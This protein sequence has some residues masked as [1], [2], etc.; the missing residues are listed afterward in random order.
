MNSVISLVECFEKNP[1]LSIFENFNEVKINCKINSLTIPEIAFLGEVTNS[2]LDRDKLTIDLIFDDMDPV[3][4]HFND[5]LQKFISEIEEFSSLME[6]DSDVI[7]KLTIEKNIDINNC[8][9]IFFLNNFTEFLSNLSFLGTLYTLKNVLGEKPFIKLQIMDDLPNHHFGTNT[10]IFFSGS[11]NLEHE[12]MERNKILERR[13][14]IGN[15]N[16]A[17]DYSFIPEDFHL[18]VRCQNEILNRFFDKLCIIFSIIYIADF[19]NINNDNDMYFKI[20]GYKLIEN[21]LSF[22]NLISDEIKVFYDIYK[23]IYNGGNISDKVG[24]ARNIIS[25]HIRYENQ[26]INLSFNTLN[27]IKSGYEIYLKD[28]VAQYIEVKNK[29]SEFLLD[30]ALRTS[31]LVN[32]FAN[33]LRNNH[34]LFLT[35]FVSV[36]VFNTLSTG[37]LSKI[38]TKD[39]TY[40]SYGLLIVSFI[41]LIATIIQTNMEKNRFITQY[42]RLKRMYDDILDPNDILNIFKETDH[43]EDIQFIEQKATIYSFVWLLEI[44]ILYI[45]VY[46]LKS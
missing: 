7:L 28:N 43:R 29:V 22:N 41:Y 18:K 45:V 9:S 3:T 31:D 24:L 30:L 15:F 27:S 11:V 12:T 40:I 32:S 21:V 36:L 17:S 16:N 5:S 46:L 35:F 39:I 20:N 34:F 19:S 1:S 26:P 14:S 25:L 13:N 44:I 23:W 33:A 42:N 37:K 8:I 2:F 4:F 38:F 6:G 10:F